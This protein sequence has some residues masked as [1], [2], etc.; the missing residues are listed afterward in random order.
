[1]TPTPILTVS[2]TA[3]PTPAGPLPA[4]ELLLNG[5]FE[6]DEAWVFGDTPIRGAYE[7]G[8]GLNG[9]RAARLGIVSGPGRFSFSS[10]WQRV[11]IPPEAKQIRLNANIYPINQGGRGNSQTIM[12]LNSNFRPLRTLTREAS[13]SQTWESRAYDLPELAGRTVYIYFSVVN[14]GGPPA[15]MYVDDVSLTWAP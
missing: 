9:S 11:T 15:A 1:M 14:Q 5:G 2:P 13:N 8:V 10:V 6:A 4:G 7:T 3:T 12:I